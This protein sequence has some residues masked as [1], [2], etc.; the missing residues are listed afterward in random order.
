VDVVSQL[1]ELM[2][3]SNQLFR[4]HKSLC[5]INIDKARDDMICERTKF[6]VENMEKLNELK[7]EKQEKVLVGHIKKLIENVPKS[8]LNCI[9]CICNINQY[10]SGCEACSYIDDCKMG[11]RVCNKI[12]NQKECNRQQ[13][14]FKDY[15]KTS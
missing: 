3:K 14:L 13:A 1:K 2:D 12:C 9:P 15:R 4:S 11:I 6:I 10:P 5:S 8:Q 7:L